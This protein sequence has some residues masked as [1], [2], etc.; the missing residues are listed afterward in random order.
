MGFWN[1]LGKIALQAAPYVAAPFTAGASLY[2]VPATQKLGQKWAE[3][4]A[5]EAAKKGLAPSKF[6]KYLGYASSIA[7]LASGTGAL[8]KFGSAAYSGAKAAGAAG[9]AAK[10]AKGAS[11]AKKIAD[12]AKTVSTWQD[13]LRQGGQ[14]ASG[15]LNPD[16]GAGQYG[17]GQYGGG[18]YVPQYDPRTSDQAQSTDRG[19]GPSA[20]YGQ[21][22]PELS[23]FAR[24]MYNELGPVMGAAN[25][26]NPNLAFALGQGRMEAMQNQPFRS[27]YQVNA[28]GDDDQPYSYQQPPIYP[29]Y[30]NQP[31]PQRP[32]WQN[33]VPQQQENSW[34]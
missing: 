6:D 31:G 23:G 19:I 8:G 30:M 33:Y 29:Q 32:V 4:D 10:A 22:R 11:T 27:G 28:V 3:H 15:M 26:N 14:I 20:S 9:T 5:K 1:K 21:V 24:R 16:G 13:R 18:G 2:A 25:Q 12:T 34:N 7:S 17:Q